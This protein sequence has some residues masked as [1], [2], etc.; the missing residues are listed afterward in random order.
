MSISTLPSFS[1][2]GI[3]VRTSNHNG[4][5][6]TDI[7]ALWQRFMADGIIASIPNMIEQNIH[8]IYTEYEGDYTQ[9][10]TVLLGMKVASLEEVP[11]GLTGMT[12]AEAT[13]QDFHCQGKM[14]DGV[15][16]QE[17]EKIWNM[18]IDRAYTA[19]LEIYDASKS[20]NE[21]VSMNIHIA[22]K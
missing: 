21:N 3:T 2:I 14:T 9:P 13:Y 15:V 7:P 5:A 1:V 18:P 11:E 19:D 17:W 10:Y 4:A 8:C 22:I 12:F 16:Y 6:G 20:D